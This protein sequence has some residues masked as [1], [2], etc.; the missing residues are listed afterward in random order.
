[1]EGGGEGRLDMHGP[2]PR[3]VRSDHV[4]DLALIIDDK[5]II[6]LEGLGYG[7]RV[8]RHLVPDE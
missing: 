6:V 7:S 2:A 5:L 4:L 3:V 1:M 8:G